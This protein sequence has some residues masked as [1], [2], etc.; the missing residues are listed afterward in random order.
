MKGSLETIT[1]SG[2]DS[3][4]TY[5]DANL[6]FTG[7]NTRVASANIKFESAG[8]VI[9]ITDSGEGYTSNTVITTDSGEANNAH[10]KFT[11]SGGRIG[12]DL[13]ETI[14]SLSDP[15]VTSKTSGGKY[16]PGD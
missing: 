5:K 8:S 12:R 4:K 6:V 16:F 10:L 11:F 1:V 13:T 2:Y 7:A 3:S 14:I 15:E 9:N